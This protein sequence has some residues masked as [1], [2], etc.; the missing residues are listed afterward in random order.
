MMS[1]MQLPDF[2]LDPAD[3]PI[4][5]AGMVNAVLRL[6]LAWQPARQH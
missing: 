6:P 1:D 3:R 4:F 2:A 5:G